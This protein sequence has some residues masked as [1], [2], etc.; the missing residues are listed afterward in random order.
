MSAN[1]AKPIGPYETAAATE[2]AERAAKIAALSPVPAATVADFLEAMR[3]ADAARAD[4]K[5]S[6]LRRRATQIAWAREEIH[7]SPEPRP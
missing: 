4:P 7:Y 3:E 1:P 5:L 6:E 2:A